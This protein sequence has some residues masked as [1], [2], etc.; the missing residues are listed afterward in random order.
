MR[1]LILAILFLALILAPL[2]TL[3]LLRR[4]SE[5]VK[6]V[7]VSGETQTLVEKVKAQIPKWGEQVTDFFAKIFPSL[8]VKVKPV[9]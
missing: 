1:R 3:G 4:T 9:E 6:G 2:E 8:E 5:H 7:A